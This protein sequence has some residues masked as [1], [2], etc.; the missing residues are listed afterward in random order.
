MRGFTRNP[1]QMR[2]RLIEAATHLIVTQ[3]MARL[4]DV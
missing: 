1:E 2:A 4:T 3:G